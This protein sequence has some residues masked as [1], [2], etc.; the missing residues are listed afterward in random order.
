MGSPRN[1]KEMERNEERV[2]EGG[3]KGRN[4]G[5]RAGKGKKKRDEGREKEQKGKDGHPNFLDV[6]APLVAQSFKVQ[7]TISGLTELL[8]ITN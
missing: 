8:L 6:G 5:Q 1:K 7:T 4:K 2:G 3:R